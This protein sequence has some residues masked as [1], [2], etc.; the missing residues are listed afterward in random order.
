VTARRIAV[1]TTAR[2][3]YGLYRPLLRAIQEDPSLDLQLIAAASH[4]DPR[5]GTISEIESDGFVPAARVNAPLEGDGPLAIA[6]VMAQTAIGVAEALCDLKPDVMVV[7]GD[8]SEMAA[9][10]AAATPFLVPIAHIAGGAITRGAIDDG[11]RHAISK[12]SHIH[13]PETET[14]RERLLR[15]GEE[16]WRIHVTGSLSI[17]N[18]LALK[19]LTAGEITAQFGIPLQ[20]PMLMVTLHPET[21]EFSHT[22]AYADALFAALEDQ[23]G[24]ILFTYPGADAGGRVIIARIEDFVR[25]H[26]A[27]AQAVPHLGTRAYFSLMMQARAMVGNSSS[28]ILEA[29]S[30]KLPVVNI[31]R[32][33]EGRAAPANVIG[34]GFDARAIHAAITRATSPAFRASLA[35]L[36]NPYGQGNAAAQMVGILKNVTLDNTLLIKGCF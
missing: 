35:D 23:D 8:R 32:R 28:G 29:A 20:A 12:L 36:A 15:L 13:F 21:R 5:F 2:S 31:G 9:V 30:F 24:P 11:F 16:A 4:L 34:C 10:V 19:P 27:K 25:R 18:A 22:A 14:Q 7:L 3:E 33:Q 6:R 1:V 17:D 26:S